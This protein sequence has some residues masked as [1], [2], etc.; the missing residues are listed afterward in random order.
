MEITIDFNLLAILV[1]SILGL[2]CIS[3]IFL[4]YFLVTHSHKTQEPPATK[5]DVISDQGK[6]LDE[7][8]LST[9]LTFG[10]LSLTVLFFAVDGIFNNK[11]PLIIPALI[12]LSFSSKRTRVYVKHHKQ[13]SLFLCAILLIATFLL[14]H[15][16]QGGS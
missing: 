3:L 16:M 1:L 8:E 2:I 15:L 12:F 7:L 10:G 14:G 4:T 9:L 13:F 11:L 6:I 5:G